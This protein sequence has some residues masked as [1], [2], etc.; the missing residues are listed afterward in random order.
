MSS[1]SIDELLKELEFDNLK[2]FNKVLQAFGFST[3]SRQTKYVNKKEAIKIAKEVRLKELNWYKHKQQ[4]KDIYDKSGPLK[5]LSKDSSEKVLD[6]L[7]YKFDIDN[8]I[9]LKQNRIIGLVTSGGYLIG[10]KDEEFSLILE[11]KLN[12]LIGDR[13]TGKST[14]LQ[15]LGMMSNS[16]TLEAKNI[17]LDVFSNEEKSKNIL[18]RNI[19]QKLKEYDISLYTLLFIVNEKI[20]AYYINVKENVYGVFNYN[21]NENRWLLIKSK[22]SI[23]VPNMLIVHQ[24]ELIKISEDQNQMYINTLLDMFNNDLKQIRTLTYKQLKQFKIQHSR[25]NLKIIKSKY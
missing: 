24:A 2:R 23:V 6:S 21:L 10:K 18:H 16:L 8:S 11:N 20:Y 25:L 19:K 17:I 15:M 14:I 22:T 5:E 12:V 7:R 13:G 3:F 1:I 4:E 9:N